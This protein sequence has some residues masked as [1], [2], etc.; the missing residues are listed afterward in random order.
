MALNLTLAAELLPVGESQTLVI[1][2]SRQTRGS[3]Q[4]HQPS[5]CSVTRV[6][7]AP[8]SPEGEF[9]AQPLQRENSKLSAAHSFA[10][11]VTM[12]AFPNLTAVFGSH[13]SEFR[14]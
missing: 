6:T 8:A 13:V 14:N 7:R 2:S 11:C 4:Q 12:V 5:S 3:I 9:Q 10:G 1:G